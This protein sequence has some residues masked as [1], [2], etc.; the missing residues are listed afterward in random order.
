MVYVNI[1]PSFLEQYTLSHNNEIDRFLAKSLLNQP[2]QCLLLREIAEI[3]AVETL[4]E[5][6][7][8]EEEVLNP[9]DRIQME[10]LLFR[11]F[12]HYLNR[13]PKKEWLYF[14]DVDQADLIFD[15]ISRYMRNHL[16]TVSVQELE[17]V[18]F[19]NRN[20]YNQLIRSKTGH[21]FIHYLQQLK[22]DHAKHLLETTMLSA[23]EISTRIGY[24]NRSYFYTMFQQRTGM[25]PKKYRSVKLLKNETN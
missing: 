13:T 23:D 4:L 8:R 15:E 18:F 22:I 2:K 14:D 16:D 11:R 3:D 7:L 19:Y 5:L 1:D 17:R 6:L 21:S 25:T 12:S 20:F 9:V 10:L 24:S